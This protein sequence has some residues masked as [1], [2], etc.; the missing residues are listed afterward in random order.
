MKQQTWTSLASR[1]RVGLFVVVKNG[2]KKQLVN[3]AKY[4]ILIKAALLSRMASTLNV[5]LARSHAVF[6]SIIF[7][8][9]AG[10]K[11]AKLDFLCS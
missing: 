3:T 1:T 7:G 4:I 10:D 6:G 11:S 2:M 9:G 5:V 8:G